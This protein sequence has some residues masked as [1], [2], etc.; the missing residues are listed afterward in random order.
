[1]RAVMYRNAVALDLAQHHPDDSVRERE[2]EIAAILTPVSKAWGSDIGV[3][4]ASLGIQVH[5]GMGYVEE[6]GAA[7]WWRDSRI[8]PIYEGTNGIQAIDLV[9]RKVPLRS[10]RAI[11]DLLDEVAAT[12]T[13]V[14]DA[15]ADVGAALAEAHKAVGTATDALLANDDRR[16]SLAAATSY[17]AMLG[18]LLGGWLLLVGAVRAQE[19][20]DGYDEDFLEGRV[21]VARFYA[22]QVLSAVPG[23]LGSVAAGATAL[24]DIPETS[25]P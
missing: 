7:Q 8:A 13:S 2:E 23:R 17:L 10:G 18:D 9:A 11:G 20:P 19:G 6:T 4:L 22:A 12:A 1:M 14:P 15:L 5:G 25:F 3:E 21:A 24:F 16:D